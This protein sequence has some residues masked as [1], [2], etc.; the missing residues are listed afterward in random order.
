MAQKKINSM[1]PYIFN[2]AETAQ[3]CIQ[4]IKD[5]MQ[6]NGNANTKVI[7]GISGGKDSTVVAALCAQALG[8][9]RILGVMMPP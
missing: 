4:W 3:A 5:W 6:Q 1:K 9:E 2:V 8:K 7:I